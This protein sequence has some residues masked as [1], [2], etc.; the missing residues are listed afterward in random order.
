MTPPPGVRHP[1][2]EFMTYSSA[3]LGNRRPTLQCGYNWSYAGTASVPFWTRKACDSATK[4]TWKWRRRCAPATSWWRYSRP[5]SC[6]A[7]T[8]CRS[9]AG[10]STASSRIRDFAPRTGSRRWLHPL[11]DRRSAVPQFQGGHG[12]TALRRP[13]FPC[14]QHQGQ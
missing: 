14:S 13:S 2:A 3:T 4:K 6:A 11:R 9:C 1:A 5:T 8:A 10:R 12:C 7:P